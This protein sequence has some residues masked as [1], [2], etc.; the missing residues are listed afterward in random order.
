[1]VLRYNTGVIV[2]TVSRYKADISQALGKLDPVEVERALGVLRDAY[3]REAGIFVIGNGGSA[4]NANHFA[5]DF[6]KNAVPPNGKRIRVQSLCTNSAALTALG[7]DMGFDRVF[8]EQLANLLRKGDVLVAYSV[9]GNSRDVTMA[10]QY[11]LDHGAQVVALTGKDGGDLRRIANVCIHVPSQSYE[12][13][14]DIHSIAAHAF[15]LCFKRL[16]TTE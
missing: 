10:A 8:V 13:V 16:Y 11:A 7:N 5:A 14:E 4:A 12:L 1:M 6:G 9:S 15:T 2:E 3:E